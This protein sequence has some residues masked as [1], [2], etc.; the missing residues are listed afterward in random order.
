MACNQCN[1]CTDPCVG[2]ECECAVKITTDCSTYMGPD[3]PCSSIPSGTLLTNVIQLLDAFICEKFNSITSVLSLINVGTG[4]GIFKG[5]NNLGQKELKSITS[6]DTSVTIT[7]TADE[8]N[9]SVT[10]LSGE[11][12]TASNVG[13]QTEIFKQKTGAD[14]EFKTL[15][16]TG[17]T[18]LTEVGDVIQVGSIGEANTNSNVGTGVGVYKQKTGVDSELKT[19]IGGTNVTITS[20][21][22]E[23]TINSSSTPVAEAGQIERTT[24]FTLDSSMNNQV[25][26]ATVS[27]LSTINIT[28]PTGLPTDFK[29]GVIRQGTGAV[30]FVA[31]SGVTINTA[32]GLSIESQYYQGFIQK[33][34]SGT[35]EYV[36]LGNLV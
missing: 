18:T 2:T 32:T 21:A 26:F 9:L 15:Q 36:A 3:L 35:D 30:N 31:A 29:C 20:T 27:G 14:L 12:N 24:S 23:I 34:N 33:R 16:A 11:T 10:G 25:I 6:T 13:G 4:A 7:E 17:S 19:L 5:N 8:I 22:D 1:E 28:V